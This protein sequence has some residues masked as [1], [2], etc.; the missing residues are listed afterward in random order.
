M[1]QTG[2]ITVTGSTEFASK[3][4]NATLWFPVESFPSVVIAKLVFQH[5]IH[6]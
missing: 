5:S 2:V 4:P 6:R 3:G 1:V